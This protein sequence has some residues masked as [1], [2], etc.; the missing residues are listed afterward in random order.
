MNRPP[1]RWT[2]LFPLLAAEAAVAVKKQRPSSSDR[3]PLSA[4]NLWTVINWRSI[5]L[6]RRP[7]QTLITVMIRLADAFSFF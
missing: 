3:I 2:F 1:C 4:I 7:R 6:H 5:L